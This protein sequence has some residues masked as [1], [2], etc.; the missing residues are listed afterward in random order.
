MIAKGIKKAKSRKAHAIDLLNFV[1]V[2][3]VQGKGSLP[4]LTEVRLINDFNKFK[5]TYSGLMFT[6][7]VCELIKFFAEEGQEDPGIYQNIWNLLEN[8]LPEKYPLLL[9][10]LILRLLYNSGNLPKLNEDVITAENLPAD[11]LRLSANPIGYTAEPAAASS[12]EPISDRL[13]KVQRFII[14]QDYR[15]VQSI[16]LTQLEEMQLYNLHLNW[17][18]NT[19]E[20][21]LRTAPMFIQAIGNSS[22]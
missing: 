21:E 14:N 5:Q 10:T 11:S 22:E 17:L 13:Y 16:Q 1:Q 4:I 7:Q 9:A 18:Q 15:L 19:L 12:Q 3:L 2:K 6:Q 20:R 8:A